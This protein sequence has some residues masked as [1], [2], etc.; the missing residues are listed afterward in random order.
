MVRHPEDTFGHCAWLASLVGFISFERVEKVVACYHLDYLMVLGCAEIQRFLI[1]TN[2]WNMFVYSI[3]AFFFNLMALESVTSTF[4]SLV[5]SYSSF[6]NKKSN[7]QK[8]VNN[9][10]QDILYIF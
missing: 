8:W 3:V 6:S 2:R 7:V 1:E 9:L 10:T 4:N 5:P